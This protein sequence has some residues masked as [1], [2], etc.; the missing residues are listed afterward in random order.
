[1]VTMIE[2]SVRVDAAVAVMPGNSINAT[3]EC[4]I[5]G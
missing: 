4:V 1:M 3:M 2:T 5:Y